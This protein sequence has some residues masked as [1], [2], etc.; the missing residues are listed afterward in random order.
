MVKT[1]IL[2]HCEIVTTSCQDAHRCRKFSH[3]KLVWLSVFADLG[4]VTS[5]ATSGGHTEAQRFFVGSNLPTICI[6][7]CRWSTHVVWLHQMPWWV[8]W[9]DPW[10]C[11]F[12]IFVGQLGCIKSFQIRLHW[13]LLLLFFLHVSSLSLYF[14][15]HPS[16]MSS[17]C[18]K[19]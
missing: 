10:L 17:P 19:L 11:P 12:P 9:K 14:H 16:P 18:S 7:L 4:G 8:M 1:S 13:L 3:A 5:M 2:I 6:N 15:H